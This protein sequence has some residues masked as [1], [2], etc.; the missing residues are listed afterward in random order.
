ME[1]MQ[2]TLSNVFFRYELLDKKSVLTFHDIEGATGFLRQ[3]TGDQAQMMILRSLATEGHLCM[4]HCLTTEE[5]LKAC[6]LQLVS[7]RI[8]LL[9]QSRDMNGNG[10]GEAV[11]ENAA[12]EAASQFQKPARKTAWVEFRVLDDKTGQP[13]EGVELTIKLPDGRLERRKTDIGG[14]IE[15]NDTV[16]GDCLLNSDLTDAQLSSAYAFVRFG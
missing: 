15:I 14:F 11:E 8:K 10:A 13:V 12:R 6:A 2:K 5:I 16:E 3:F 1:I 4:T 9:K 7:G